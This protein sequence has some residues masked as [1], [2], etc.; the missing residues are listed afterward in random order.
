MNYYLILG[1]DFSASRAEIKEAYRKMVQKYHPDH[2]GE[3]ASPFLKVQEAYQVLS[4]PAR[5]RE[6]DHTLGKLA[7]PSPPVKNKMTNIYAGE[8]EPLIPQKK[9]TQPDPISLS[10]SFETYSPSFTEI[11]DRFFNHMGDRRRQKS[12]RIANLKVEVTISSE[13][14]LS[15]GSVQ[16]LLPVQIHCPLCHGS[17][18]V[19]FWACNRCHSHGIIDTEMPIIVSYPGGIHNTFNKHISLSRYGIDN[20]Y[21]TVTIRASEE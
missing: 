5:R 19:G 15:G 3:D 20:Y 11:F 21:L 16:L 14:A 17:G 13:Q 9:T 7:A 12:G 10:R 2:F 6:Y 18:H 8:P 4:D 1:I